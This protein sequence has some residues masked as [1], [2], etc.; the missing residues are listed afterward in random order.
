VLGQR[1]ND[2]FCFALCRTCAAEET[3]DLCYHNRKERAIRGVYFTEELKLAKKMG[4]EVETPL[5]MWEWPPEQRS[6]KVF[7]RFIRQFYAKKAQASGA[8]EDPQEL[9]AL[10]EELRT[11]VKLKLDPNSFKKDS[12][13]RQLAKLALNNV[14][15]SSS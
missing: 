8:P 11:T 9:A 3:Q 13:L 15:G 4:Y 10:L 2:K 14:W 1:V 5:E 7:R 6:A 12:S